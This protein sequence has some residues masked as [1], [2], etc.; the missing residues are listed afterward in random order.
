MLRPAVLHII[1]L[2][3]WCIIYLCLIKYSQV[4]HLNQHCFYLKFEKHRSWS[5]LSEYFDPWCVMR[6]SQAISRTAVMYAWHGLE[7]PIQ[8]S[9]PQRLLITSQVVSIVETEKERE[10]K[11]EREYIVNFSDLQCPEFHSPLLLYSVVHTQSIHNIK[12][13]WNKQGQ[14]TQGRLYD[15]NAML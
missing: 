12:Q 1:V 3:K 13:V 2:H 8:I 11:E 9:I 15:H 6:F 4:I 7:N 5:R 14:S 10:G